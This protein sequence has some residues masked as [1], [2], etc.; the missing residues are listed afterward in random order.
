[1]LDDLGL[2]GL[3]AS[4]IEFG[5]KN[6]GADLNLHTNFGPFIRYGTGRGLDAI[7]RGCAAVQISALQDGQGIAI[8][9]NPFEQAIKFIV[10]AFE[11]GP[12]PVDL[13]HLILDR[14]LA[15]ICGCMT[16]SYHACRKPE[17]LTP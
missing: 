7:G 6:G 14:V 8:A 1:M 16:Q 11:F 13:L 5:P 15:A 17:S 10:P 3:H 9:V 12:K 2:D 4:P